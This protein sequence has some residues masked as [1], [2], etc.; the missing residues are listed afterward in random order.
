[1]YFVLTVYKS[2]KYALEQFKWRPF[3]LIYLLAKII[4]KWLIDI[5][6]KINVVIK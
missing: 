6:K 5:R 1:M 3:A 2:E 4:L